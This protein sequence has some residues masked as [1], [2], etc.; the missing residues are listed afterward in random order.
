MTSSATA[1]SARLAM[2][3]ALTG[4]IQTCRRAA[5][6]LRGV[7]ESALTDSYRPELHYMRGP[8]PKW[9]ERHQA[10]RPVSNTANGKIEPAAIAARHRAAMAKTV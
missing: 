3:V 1:R 9:R 2:A 10:V 7:I 8:G 4:G 6:K 5:T